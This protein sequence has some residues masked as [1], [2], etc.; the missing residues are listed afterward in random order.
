MSCD[1]TKL[2]YL[3]ETK[4]MIREKIDPN[5]NKI[6]DETPFRN[7][8]NYISSKST[9]GIGTVAANAAKISITGTVTFSEITE[10]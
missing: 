2:N 4:Q 10:G 6:T 1:V 7:Y 9:A 3:N 8:V 5:G